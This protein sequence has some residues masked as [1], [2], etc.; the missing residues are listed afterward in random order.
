MTI[1][2]ISLYLRRNKKSFLHMLTIIWLFCIASETAF[3]EG[4]WLSKE[5][6]DK[7]VKVIN[8]IITAAA[9]ILWL[10][11]S[12]V[13]VFLY[14]GWVNGTL[15]GLQDYLKEIWILVSNI[16]Y[17]IFAFIIIVIAFMNIIWKWEGNWE[18]KQAMPKFIVWVLIVPFSWFFVQFVLAISAVL[19]VG[20]LTLPYDS[21]KDQSLLWDALADTKLWGTT[22]CK[23]VIIFFSDEQP[24]WSTDLSADWENTLSENIRCK[25]E[26]SEVTVEELFNWEWDGL[27]NTIFGVISVYTYGILQVQNMDTLQWFNLTTIKGIADLIFSMLFNVL[28]IIIYMLL[29]V[30]L[31]LALLVRGIRLWIYAM[32]SPAFGLLYFFGKWSDGFW[33]SGEKFNI[34]E[35]IALALVPVYVAAALSFG[36]IFILVA[37]EWIKQ[38]ASTDDLDT[39]EAGGFSLSIKWAHG[40]GEEEVSVIWKLIVE[41]FWV[42]ILWIAVMAALWSSKTTKAIVEPIAA[43][44]KS[45]WELAA[46]APTYAPIIPTGWW[47]WSAMSVTWLQQVWSTISSTAEQSARARWSEFAKWLPGAD[48]N[49]IDLSTKSINAL[50]SFQANGNKITRESLSDLRDAIKAGWSIA[51]L[52]NDPQFIKTINDIK[53]SDIA[54]KDNAILKEDISI[55][56]P[57]QLAKALSEMD[58]LIDANYSSAGTLMQGTELWSQATA[59]S[60]NE[61]IFWEWWGEQKTETTN[62]FNVRIDGSD[63]KDAKLAANR[64]EGKNDTK[65]LEGLNKA[66][67][68]AGITEAA[69]RTAIIEA[70]KYSSDDTDWNGVAD[71]GE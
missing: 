23:D 16:V 7:V 18:L 32:L 59:R 62:T 56:K 39:I 1:S 63:I 25:W 52:A 15:F 30:A 66:M 35:F 47:P 28:F 50:K 37:S 6:S 57:D 41:L 43:F 45:V 21:F 70:S 61:R 34:K 24:A 22:I 48:W 31:F 53:K 2:S 17:F 67:T 36:L 60:V 51:T 65:N 26:G 10:L 20:M 13:T 69:Y 4:E 44:W 12:F 64:L 58:R 14:P 40:W 11:T 71:E 54:F 9:S 38:K 42:V 46:K 5:Q 55:W 68:D 3:A 27:D 19:T 49:K 33:E 8:G 29:M